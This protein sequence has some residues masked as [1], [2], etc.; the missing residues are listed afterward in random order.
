MELTRSMENYLET[1]YRIRKRVTVRTSDLSLR[2]NVK[3]ASVTQMLRKLHEMGLVVY[4]PTSG[5]NSQIL[6]G[7]LQRR[8]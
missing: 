8:S 7:N 2:L 1:I 4:H 5:L 3:P 6:A